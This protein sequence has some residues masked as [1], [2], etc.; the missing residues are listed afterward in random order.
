MG[1]FLLDL[2]QESMGLLLSH[3]LYAR[4]ILANAREPDRYAPANTVYAPNPLS[5]APAAILALHMLNQVQKNQQH[6]TKTGA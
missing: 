4:K 3:K 5:Y 6:S 2:Q 1:S